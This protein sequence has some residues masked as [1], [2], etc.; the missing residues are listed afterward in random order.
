MD[1]EPMA[2]NTRRFALTLTIPMTLAACAPPMTAAASTWRKADAATEQRATEWMNSVTAGWTPNLGQIADASG[3]AASD[4]LYSANI[5]G[6]Q[7]HVTTS[8]I[9][10]YFVDRRN[11]EEEGEERAHAP[12]SNEEKTRMYDWARL[13]LD[14]MG[15]SIRPE[16]AR[17]E[18]PIAGQGTSNYY[19]PHCPDG[20]T[21]VPTYGRITFP[22]VYRGIDWVIRNEPGEGVH[23]DFVV[24]PGAD[25]T[26]IRLQY[27]GA[28]A[29]TVS[30]DAQSLLV[31]TSLG[32]V[33]E[34]ALRCYQDDP[35]NPVGARFHV[36]GTAVSVIVDAYD[37]SRPLVIDPPMVWS[38]YYGG[39][40]YDG[41]RSIYCDNANQTVYVVGYNAS[42]NLPVL[43][44]GGGAH[45]QGSFA[46]SQDGF[47]WK[48]N[49]MG[50]RQWATYY[51]GSLDEMNADC[52]VDASGNLYVCGSTASADFPTQFLAGAYNQP[53][54]GGPRD[55]FVLKFNAA[56]VRQWATLYGGKSSD[57]THAIATDLAGKVFVCGSTT[58]NDLPVFNPGG[59]AYF[60]N[61][62]GG[63]R[64][65]FVLRFAALGALEWAT[66]YGGAIDSDEAYGIT[67][68]PGSVYV[69]GTTRST[70]FPTLNPGGG[71]YFQPALAGD[72]DTHVS[73]FSPAGVQ[74]W[75]TYFGGDSTDTGD[76]PVVDANGNLFICGYTVSSNLPTVNPG[77]TSYFQ[78]ALAG[79][80]DLFI[81]K[82]SATHAAVWSTYF[83]GSDNDFLQGLMGK[84]LAVDVQGRVYMTG[85]TFSL[86]LPVLDPGGG[87]F[88][89]GTFV[90]SSDATL[91]EFG[92][93][94]TLLW[95]TYF[96][97]T[98]PEFGSGV[99]VGVGGCLFATGE[100]IL[101]ANLPTMNPGGG[102]WYQP[103]NAGSDDG[104]I[105]RFCSKNSACCLDFN[106][107]AVATQADCNALGG[108]AFFPDQP[109]STTV[110]TIH[111][112]ICGTKFADANRNG[113][114][115]NGEAG[116]PGWTIALYYPNGPLY[117]TKITDANGNY[118]FND[119]PCG[120]WTVTEVQK[121]GFVQT[122]PA[123]AHTVTLGT[124][125]TQ[126]GVNFGNYACSTTLACIG[127]PPNIAAWWPF[128]GGPPTGTAADV[129]HADPSRNV[130]Q[131]H[132][133]GS[134]SV[135]EMLCFATPAD[136]AVVPASDQLDLN[137]GT[138]SFAIASW[139]NA[140]SS[141]GGRR[142]I[143]E[144]R[145]RTSSSA[146]H[147]RGWALYLDGLQSFLEL[148][149]GA[150]PQIVPGPT[151]T[152]DGWTHLV[153]SI[154]RATG[155]G[156]WHLDG[157]PAPAFDFVPHNGS[158]SNQADVAIGQV[159]SA[160]GTAPGFQGCIGALAIFSSPLTAAA[161]R[162]AY[163]P[164]PIG[165]CPEFAL[166]PQVKTFCQSDSTVQV[167]FNLVNNTGAPQSYHWSMAGL[168]AGAGC[169]VAGPTQIT[170][171]AGVITVP[172][173]ST[174]AA[175]CVTI[176]RPAGLTAQ[177]ATAC[178]VLT[179]MNDATGI[180]RT[181]TG[182]LRADNSCWCA[183]PQQQGAVPVPARLAAG[184]VIGIGIK[185]PCDPVATMAYRMS[186][187][188]IDPNHPDPQALSL[189][190]LP[191]GTPV[192]GA[193][194]AGPGAES[195]LDVSVSYP[196]RYDFAAR[197]EIVLEADTDGDGSM[198][199]LSGT[200]VEATYDSTATVA[201]PALPP[202]ER[203]VRLVT[204]PNPFFSGSTIEFT[205]AQSE[206]LDLGIYD[207]SGRLV[208]SV[209]RG[210]LAAGPHRFAWNGRDERGRRAPAGVYFVRLG[211]G[212][213]QLEA[214]VV[215]IQ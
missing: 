58:S 19:L 102:A 33:R 151:V 181:R 197:Y 26:Q 142:M 205:L 93:D 72:E 49:Q 104:Y 137:F 55:G 27:E 170:P 138:G 48:F 123:G 119:I 135:P 86:D 133:G 100:T 95:S 132:T 208:R 155:Q 146:Y 75:A 74:L 110:C 156:R 89:Q 21:N 42:T 111:C 140:S 32:E 3:R 68:A 31:R 168:P 9:S 195:Q 171:S 167:C 105:A 193:V 192:T 108:T 126:N 124:G 190:G 101:P 176:K 10:H 8:G 159:S 1:G 136:Y 145:A 114:Q 186:A 149:T 200:V 70:T 139:F 45:F 178:F 116:L 90:G 76:E 13:D 25:A 166:M 44:P 63:T 141:G 161:A 30:D 109:C 53:A 206:N 131:I 62:L 173:G 88:F 96:G 73:R 179:F 77:G 14:L 87:S 158:V 177:N 5:A 69:V 51:G 60:D 213:R 52:A 94:G 99:S 143:V 29:I 130:A 22:D 191:P 147:T 207:L 82:F 202:L 144:K 184:T 215:K 182:M 163:D 204:R 38:T 121:P 46:G 4:V 56:G 91:T 201:V 28:T 154:D 92:N 65:A 103:V 78:G 188:W 212:G 120:T 35:S 41:P 117:A 24:R 112:T 134:S 2:L 80:Y 36:E 40:G 148:G 210:K 11:E 152:P 79:T 85:M 107:V 180:C 209:S 34:G 169:T 118:C 189:N 83:G 20:V 160:F 47:I 187:E 211:G 50:V 194:T 57:Y 18:N 175:I 185:H 59:G 127:A 157:A 106:C 39:T 98:N 66:Y 43:N 67:T 17:L 129:A 174:S 150:S 165:W 61:T 128:N 54:L 7:V 183:T 23:H 16:R 198:E 196:I 12:A 115:D 164:G 122:H 214:K 162:K 71:A 64:D 37:H 153:V 125:T 97:S 113:V 172:A 6:A 199:R 15:A 203:S 81:A 84:P